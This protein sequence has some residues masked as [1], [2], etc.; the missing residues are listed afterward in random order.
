MGDRVISA[1]AKL[2]D[3]LLCLTPNVRN[4]IAMRMD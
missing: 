2:G 1:K 3:P 4:L